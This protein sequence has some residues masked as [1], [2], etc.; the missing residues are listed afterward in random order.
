MKGLRLKYKWLYEYPLQGKMYP[1]HFG[2][3]SMRF[4][5]I[6][7][8]SIVSLYRCKQNE[9]GAFCPKCNERIKT[10]QEKF[11]YQLDEWHLIKNRGDHHVVC[12]DGQISEFEAN[13]QAK[14]EDELKS[15]VPPAH[16][17]PATG[18]TQRLGVRGIRI[19][20]DLYTP[21][22]LLALTLYRDECLKIGRP[23]ASW[24]TPFTASPHVVSKRLG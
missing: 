13:I 24:S 19:I 23:P 12:I 1:I 6:K 14:I 9:E 18:L 3:S 5:C 20:L 7:C 17:F 16:Q 15:H 21:R 10:N 8:L 4:R 2:I 22:N 11:G